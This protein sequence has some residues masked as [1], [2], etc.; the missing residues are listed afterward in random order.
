MR[1]L[2]AAYC[3]ASSAED[4]HAQRVSISIS[5]S[6]SVSVQCPGPGVSAIAY[7]TG[8]TTR[9]GSMGVSM[10]DS[11]RKVSTRWASATTG[12]LPS[13]MSAMVRDVDAGG[14]DVA[15]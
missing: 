8:A 11:L 13:L 14:D 1:E 7:S 10:G 12:I 6:I 9:A 5:I 4:L 15:G 3:Q 2:V